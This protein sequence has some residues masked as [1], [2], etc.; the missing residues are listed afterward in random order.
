MSKLEN[1]FRQNLLGQLSDEKTLVDVRIASN[2]A[3]D[4]AVSF[5]VFVA[6]NYHYQNN[7]WW[8]KNYIDEALTTEELLK[9]FEDALTEEDINKL[10]NYDRT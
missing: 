2:I 10:R 6:E 9:R 4:F 5:L 1:T 3:R 8:N 7:G